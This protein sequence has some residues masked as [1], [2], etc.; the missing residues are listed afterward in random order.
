MLSS[1]SETCHTYL[2][3]YNP[4]T[5]FSFLIDLDLDLNFSHVALLT[6]EPLS[7]ALGIIPLSIQLVN[8]ITT[9]KNLVNAYRSAAKEL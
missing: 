9:I 4:S 8:T 2:A 1:Q 6:M 7:L 5:E 3:G